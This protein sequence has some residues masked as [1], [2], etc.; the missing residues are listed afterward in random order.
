VTWTWARRD[1]GALM[2]DG[3]PDYLDYYEQ[4]LTY[5]RKLGA[6]FAQRYPKVASRLRLEPAQCE[7]PHVERLLEGFA[8]VAARLH[9]RLDEDFPEVSE[10]LLEMLH[11]QLVRPVPSMAVVELELDPAQGILPGGFRVP[12]GSR[13]QSRPVQGVPCEFRTAYDTTLW[14]VRVTGAQWTAPDGSAGREAV[15]AIRLQ[16][17]AFEGARLDALAMD[18]W[19]L[20]LSA[21][22][23]VTDTLLELLLN[24]CLQVTVR[25]PDRPGSAPALLGPGAFRPVG[26]GEDEALLPRPPRAFAGY[27]LLHE[28]FA[29]PE[30]FRFVELAGLGG[31]LRGVQAGAR[32]E[33]TILFSAFEK[34]ERRQA[35]ELALSGDTFR[36]GCVPVV[37]LF[38]RSAEPIL[39]TERQVEHLVVADARRRL[40]VEVWAVDGVT[41]L[42]DDRQGAQELPPLYSHRHDASPDGRTLFWQARRRRSGWRSDTATE[43]VLTFVDL[44]GTLRVPDHDTAS[45]RITA[46]NGDLPSRLPFGTDERGDFTLMSGGPVRRITALVRPTPAVPPRLGSPLLWRLISSLSLNHLSVTD[47]DA[48]ALRELLRLHIPT[49]SESARRQVEGLVGVTGTPTFARVAAPHGIAFARGRRV[50]LEF[51]EEQYRG[52]GMF[53][54]ASVLERFLPLYATMNSFTQVAVR[55]RQR[56]R[57]VVEWAPRAGWRNLL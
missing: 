10:A 51:D 56:R 1:D 53:L 28:L 52:G 44:A 6:E 3:I 48:A 41:L 26:F 42:A 5:L 25:N 37:N 21:D 35:V 22:A 57:P 8:F 38:E 46:C 27:G 9:R 19:R 36:P 16:L 33:V 30:K 49:D 43:V 47:G 15:G 7:D 54:V 40:E 20:F 18:A 13:L 39:L 55:S 17:Q 4:E 12:R 50:E 23:G 11:P 29:F 32:A 45:V 14:P 2:A 34:A 24:N 31:A